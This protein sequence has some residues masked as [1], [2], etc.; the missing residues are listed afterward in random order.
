M[1]DLSVCIATYKRWP[2]C[3]QALNSLLAQQCVRL[4]VLIVND[5]P[6]TPPPKKLKKKIE[7]L[8]NVS[9]LNHEE[10]SGLA[11]ARNTA[12]RN[13]SAP[14]FSFCDDDD[15]WDPFFAHRL[16]KET[17][18]LS[19]G[20][21]VVLGVPSGL[22]KDFRKI[23]GHIH[24]LQTLILWGVTPPV[25]SQLYSMDLVY[26]S[27]GYDERIKSG[28]DHDLWITLA[29]TNP[30]VVLSFGNS[31]NVGNS[32]ERERMTNQESKRREGIAES[33][34][35]WKPKIIATFGEDF[36]HHFEQS[37]NDYLDYRFFI[38]TLQNGAWREL[39]KRITLQ[40]VLLCWLV[41]HAMRKLT[42]QHRINLFPPFKASL[43]EVGE[44]K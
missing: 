38:E 24:D 13:A 35:I 28:V 27:G 9:I 37:Y 4:E 6:E 41:A 43:S 18:R 30:E 17:K 16:L 2:L 44:V 42:H 5:S 21:G 25:G 15:Q 36:W 39:L 23:S 34:Q 40:P 12:I 19:S 22:E 33:L 7:S 32:P 14:F 3:E 26:Q 29:P 8:S 10:N 31:A 20:K 1:F 11:A